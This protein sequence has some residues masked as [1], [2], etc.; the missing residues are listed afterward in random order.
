MPL[1]GG[2]SPQRTGNFPVLLM[3]CCA[4]VHGCAD[5][6]DCDLY[7]SNVILP[8]NLKPLHQKPIKKFSYH[9]AFINVITYHKK[10]TKPE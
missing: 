10:V 8:L 7:P 2:L 9:I 4:C 3:K 6:A 1:A 5:F